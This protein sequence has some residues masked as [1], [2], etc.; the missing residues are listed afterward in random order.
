M[1]DVANVNLESVDIMRVLE[2]LPHRYPFLLVDRIVEIDGDN[3]CVGIKNVS[4]NEPH[5]QGHFPSNPVM[6][7]VLIIEGMAQTA[8]AMCIHSLGSDVH[9]KIV[10]FMSIEK[11][12]FRKTVHPGDQL[13]Y[14]VKKVHRRSTVWKFSG[15]ALVDGAVVADAQLSA[16]IA[17]A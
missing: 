16:M 1:S 17:D 10:Y 9:P 4:V 12:K 15:Q 5:F 3:S 8:G 2:L 11:A 13:R 14:V 7:G 6:P